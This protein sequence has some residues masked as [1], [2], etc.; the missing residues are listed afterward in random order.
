MLDK[1]I[2]SDDLAHLRALIARNAQLAQGVDVPLQLRLVID[3]N[4]VLADLLLLAGKRKDPAARRALQEV[5][6][7]GTIIAFVPDSLREEVE[8]HLPEL[9]QDRGIPEDSLR[10]VW[11]EYQQCLR[12][13]PVEPATATAN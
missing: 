9:A 5:I 1:T 12:F 2:R 11:K 7:S 8:E 6:D 4:V 3:T 10:K 13:H